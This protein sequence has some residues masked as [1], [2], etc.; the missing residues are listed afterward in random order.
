MCAFLLWFIV[1]HCCPRARRMYNLPSYSATDSG[2]H[3]PA[4]ELLEPPSPP[5]MSQSVNESYQS[6]RVCRLPL[7]AVPEAVPSRGTAPTSQTS[8]P[9]STAFGGKPKPRSR[10]PLCGVRPLP[11]LLRCNGSASLPPRLVQ[12]P[13]AV[14]AS[15]RPSD[16]TPAPQ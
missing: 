9:V 7:E 1:K 15:L 14:A 6:R 13:T 4:I 8:S 12:C 2:I 11:L 3:E 16:A 5:V 10:T